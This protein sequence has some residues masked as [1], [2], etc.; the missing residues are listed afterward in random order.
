M[1]YGLP[2]PDQS[3]D[4]VVACD[5]LEHIPV[6]IA[7]T[8]ILEMTRLARQRVIITLPIGEK[9]S[10][11]IDHVWEPSI[12]G[13]QEMLSVYANWKANIEV[14]DDFLLIKVERE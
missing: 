7:Q 5:C 11:N 6:Q 9:T 14:T 4:T 13:V 3:F 2:C 10:P 8:V 12:S 1:T